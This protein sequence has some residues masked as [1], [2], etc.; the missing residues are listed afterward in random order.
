MN[1]ADWTILLAHGRVF[2]GRILGDQ[3][4]GAF[5]LDSGVMLANT[6]AGPQLARPCIAKPILGLPSIRSVRADGLRIPV[7]DL[8]DDDQRAV[9]EAVQVGAEIVTKLRAANSGIVLARGK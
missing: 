5:E 7:A 2:I 8:S 3:L 4:V 1:I 9:A 6:P